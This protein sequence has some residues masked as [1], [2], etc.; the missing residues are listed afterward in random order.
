MVKGLERKLYEDWLRALD[1]FRLE[2]LSGD[3][4]VLFNNLKRRRRGTG[5][6]V[7]TFMI[8]DRT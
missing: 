6:D 8:S 1:L 2:G 7:F 4:I 5:T 3:L